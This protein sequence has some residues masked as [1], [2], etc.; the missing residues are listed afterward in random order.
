VCIVLNFNLFVKHD[1]VPVQ[2]M[3]SVIVPL[4]KSK[5][6]D[7]SAVNNY[8][9][10]AISTSISK[11]F[12]NALSK[13]VKGCDNFDAYQFGFTSGC[14][15]SLCTGILKRTLDRYTMGG[16]HVF[17]SFLDFSTA[18]NKVSYWKL[19]LKLLNDKIDVGIVRLLAFWYSN[20]QACVGS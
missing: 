8:R 4:V 19:F 5:T 16:S 1:Y 15:T 11:L 3:K 13:H 18:F 14:S 20:Q 10:I 2:F 6:G 9:A 7:M 12:E 17:A